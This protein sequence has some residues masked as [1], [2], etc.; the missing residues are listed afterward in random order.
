MQT[1]QNASGGRPVVDTG[2]QQTQTGSFQVFAG[3]LKPKSMIETQADTAS[4]KVSPVTIFIIAAFAVSLLIVIVAAVG[5]KNAKVESQR[6]IAQV[7][8]LEDARKRIGLLWSEQIVGVYSGLQDKAVAD[9]SRLN[10]LSGRLKE[11]EAEE[12]QEG[13]AK[14]LELYQTKAVQ[15]TNRLA[16]SQAYGEKILTD[17]AAIEDADKLQTKLIQMERLESSLK[18]FEA[19]A[20]NFRTGLDEL[21]LKV[22]LLRP[23]EH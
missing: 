4:K 6:R 2:S 10:S 1:D 23:V 19:Y 13:L 18:D 17:A 21:D 15:L 3:T 22:K 8:R 5:L 7:A 9:I 16:Q 20:R 12:G 11:R 14:E